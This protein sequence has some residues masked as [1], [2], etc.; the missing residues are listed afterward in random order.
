[1]HAESCGHCYIS[2]EYKH[3]VIQSMLTKPVSTSTHA[4]GGCRIYQPA[5]LKWLQRG[6]NSQSI[7]A[8]LVGGISV[9]EV[10]SAARDILEH[11]SHAN[12]EQGIAP[13]AIIAHIPQQNGESNVTADQVHYICITINGMISY[14]SCQHFVIR[15]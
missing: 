11:V 14:F 5:E 15:S 8:E 4:S 1:M 12:G 9:E 10:N 3:G 7:N 2:D 6:Q 13:S